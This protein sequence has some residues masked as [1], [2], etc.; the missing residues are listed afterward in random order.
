MTQKIGTKVGIA[1]TAIKK[2]TENKPVKVCGTNAIQQ[3]A[4]HLSKIS[5][6]KT[7]TIKEKMYSGNLILR[8]KGEQIP[9]SIRAKVRVIKD[10]FYALVVL[11]LFCKQHTKGKNETSLLLYKLV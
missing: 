10:I 5:P 11:K 7:R 3:A 6:W 2:P 4:T 8:N 1:L 9:F